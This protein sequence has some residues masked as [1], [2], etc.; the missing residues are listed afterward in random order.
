MSQYLDWPGSPDRFVPFDTVRSADVNAALDLVDAGFAMLPVPA[1]IWGDRGNYA[2]DSGAANAYVATVGAS[3]LTAYTDGL[4]LKVKAGAANTGAST[5]NLN[6]LGAKAILRADGTALLAADIKAGQVF[7]ATYLTGA[8]V[9]GAWQLSAIAL[10][11]LAGP[12]G[13]AGNA[14]YTQRRP[15][16]GN[17]APTV[18][19]LGEKLDCTASLTLTFDT[20]AALGSAFECEV[21]AIGCQVT[22][23]ASDGRTNWCMYEGEVRRFYSDGAD[24]RSKIVQPF[25]TTFAASGTFTKPPGYR[26]FAGLLWGGGGSGLKNNTADLRPGGGGGACAPLHFPESALDA[27]E[28]VT[29]GAGGTASAAAGVTGGTSTFNG[30]SAFGGTGGT[31][32][33][34]NTGGSAFITGR[35]LTDSSVYGGGLGGAANYATYGGGNGSTSSA[36][37]Q[38]IYGGAGGGGITAAGALCPTPATVFGGA[39]GASVLAGAGVA[40]T[41]PGGGGGATATGTASGAGAAGQLQF[42]GIA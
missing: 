6:A 23:P 11:G 35:S 34:T 28:T 27:T 21:S 26:Y 39:G 13:P 36:I 3:Y 40:G 41:A 42:W 5:L 4:T 32:G 30:V 24:L 37:S 12:T 1:A 16:T 38:S 2:V 31:V 29:I 14:A 19:N 25:F 9:G 7:Q 20:P 18:A 10:S 8:G 17:Y 33:T 22:I 15:L